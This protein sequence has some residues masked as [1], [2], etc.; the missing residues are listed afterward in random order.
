MYTK[1]VKFYKKFGFEF[2]DGA[3]DF[4]DMERVP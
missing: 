2:E 1:L 4:G 3:E